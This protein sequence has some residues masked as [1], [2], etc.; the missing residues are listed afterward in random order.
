MNRAT[1]LLTESIN[2]RKKKEEELLER[3]Q[4]LKLNIGELDFL[5]SEVKLR[6]VDNL[7]ILS[8]IASSH[9]TETER[10]GKPADS[11]D[12]S[13]RMG[14]IAELYGRISI[15]KIIQA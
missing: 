1:G 3:Q 8:E 5:I 12:F 2:E 6:I 11:H 9:L 10:N 4:E 13:G 15:P 7:D 14:A